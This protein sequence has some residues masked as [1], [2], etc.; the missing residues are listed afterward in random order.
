MSVELPVRIH[1]TTIAIEGSAAVI[2]G[3][4]G[5]GKSDLALRC[6]MTPP[7]TLFTGR[8]ELVSDDY[9]ELVLEGGTM[10]ARPPREIAGLLEVRGLGI[11]EVAAVERARVSLVVDLADP[12]TIERLPEI[13][14]QVDLIDR[15]FPAIRLCAKEASAPAKLLLAL[16]FLR[17]YGR[18]PE[19]K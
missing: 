13:S 6:L 3:S 5:A 12:S 19:A 2:R 18:L 8:V 11:L 7:N 17:R 15:K 9:T 10:H 16:D 1:A 4:S 14:N